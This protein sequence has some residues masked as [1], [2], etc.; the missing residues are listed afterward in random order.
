M[1]QLAN[2]TTIDDERVC[3]LLSEAA[4]VLR[5]DGW[6]TIA[7]RSRDSSI[8]MFD[9]HRTLLEAIQH[10]VPWNGHLPTQTV[11]TLCRRLGLDARGHGWSNLEEWSE[12]PGRSVIDVLQALEG[13]R[14]VPDVPVPSKGS[15]AD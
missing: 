3:A 15:M 13:G 5:D 2:R 11:D 9:C 4:R 12:S 1:V 7:T 14:T 8:A 6:T 10:V